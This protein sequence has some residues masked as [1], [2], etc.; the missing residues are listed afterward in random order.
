MFGFLFVKNNKTM[1]DFIAAF[2]G[3]SA[4]SNNHSYFVPSGFDSLTENSF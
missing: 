2:L 4:N 1:Y 3:K